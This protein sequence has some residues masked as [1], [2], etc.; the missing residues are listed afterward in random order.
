[1]WSL[2]QAHQTASHELGQ[3]VIAADR[4]QSRDA[5]ASAGH[6]DLDTLLDAIEVL[7]QAIVQIA[8]ADLLLT[9]M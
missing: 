8:D 4:R 5:P 2:G 6:D 3:R 9:T 1:V 7:A